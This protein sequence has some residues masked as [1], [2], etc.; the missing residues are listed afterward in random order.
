[1]AYNKAR[2]EKKWRHWKEKEE[3]QLRELGMDE[4]AIQEL[5][6]MNWEEFKSERRYREH[7][8]VFPEE[9]SLWTSELEE[10][11]ITG[12]QPLLDAI[13]DERLLHILLDADRKT[14]QIILLKMMG[15][16]VKEISNKT[17]MPEQT[18]YTKIGRLR[19]KFL[20]FE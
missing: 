19:K 15:F 11:D 5:R 9:S 4:S 18:I 3:K 16:T 7:Q 17:G 10:P 14:L 13:G 6:S 1:M 12:I 2:E 8:A 20:K